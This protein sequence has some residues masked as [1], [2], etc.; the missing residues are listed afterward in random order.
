MYDENGE[1]FGIDINGKEYFY[2]KNAQ[3]DVIAIV[4]SNNET[5]ATYR[6][7]SWGKL[8]SCED[9]SEN[10]EVSFLNP[11]T[12]RSYFYD[13]D[14]E[15]YF[16]K[17]R[18]YNPELCRFISADG[19][20]Q[21]GQGM[22]D[23]NMFA[24]C[25]NNPVNRVDYT[26]SSWKSIGKWLQNKWNGFKNWVSNT[27]GTENASVFIEDSIPAV[28]ISN[29]IPASASVGKRT[30]LQKKPSSKSKPVMAYS[31]YRCDAVIASSC[32][33]KINFK[34]QCYDLSLGLD[35]IGFSKS[36]YFSD[37]F[38]SSKGVK[39]DLLRMQ[40][41][42]EVSTT[43]ITWTA[44]EQFEKTNYVYYNISLVWPYAVAG[45]LLGVTSIPEYCGSSQLEPLPTP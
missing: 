43:G 36:T 34:N 31:Q 29:L 21:T 37:N 2:V 15:M 25:G 39:M 18:Y 8:I 11:Y 45:V 12:Y 20:V 23:K 24:Y 30:N 28:D 10:Q 35:N 44:D 38:Y 14:T 22:L 4:N 6:Y 7:N 26:G 9:T 41:G 40:V 32:G 1:A 42:I 5:V 33:I 16:L 13:S 19:Y 17:S 3:N 27:F